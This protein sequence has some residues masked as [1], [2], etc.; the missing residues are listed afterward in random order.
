MKRAEYAPLRADQLRWRCDAA[1]IEALRAA[2]AGETSVTAPAAEEGA[3]QESAPES[4][5]A[6]EAAPDSS[7]RRRVRPPR[8]ARVV[9][10]ERPRAPLSAPLSG[11][12]VSPAPADPLTAEALYFTQGRAL[13]SLQLGIRMEGPGYHIFV[14][15]PSSTGKTSTVKAM[16]RDIKRPQ[17]ARHDFVYVNNFEDAD[18]PHLLTLPAGEGR[19]LKRAVAR[20][21]ELLPEVVHGALSSERVE[22]ARRQLEERLAVRRELDL[23]ALQGEC[24]GAGFTLVKGGEDLA[25]I[26]VAIVVG[27]R[28]KPL[29]IDEWTLEVERGKLK[30]PDV[31]GVLAAH[32]ALELKLHQVWER[33]QAAEWEAKRR[34][35][36]VEVAEMSVALRHSAQ[37]LTPFY[38]KGEPASALFAWVEGLAKWI[39]DHLEE[40]KEYKSSKEEPLD[41]RDVRVLQVNLIHEAAAEPPVIFEQSPTL[42]NLLGTIERSGDDTHPHLDYG[43]IRGGSLLKANGGVLVVNANDMATDAPLWR[44][45]LRALRAR[46]LEIQSPDQLFASGGCPLKPTP[47]PLDVKVLAIGD[48]E[49]YRA[50]FVSNDDFG[51]VFKIKVE[52]DDG[53]PNAPESVGLYVAHADRVAREEGLPPFSAAAVGLW[54]EFGTRL[55]G[56]QDRLSTQL[57]TLTDVLREASFY[58]QEEGGARA[59]EVSAAH[60][61]R[62]LQQRFE[63]HQL[64]EDQLFKMFDDEVIELSPS[65]WEVG[66]AN[67]LTVLD[68]GDHACGHP[69]RISASVSPGEAGVVSVEREVELS[70]RL[71][72]KGALT[73]SAYLRAR[74]LPD[75]VC[76]L[77]ATL[78]FD[79]LH[80]EVEGDSASLAEAV[81]LISALSGAYVDQGVAMTGALDSR[82]R[83]QAIGGVNEKVEGF[84]R[85]CKLKGLTGAQ[86]VV[87]PR[88]NVRDLALRQE[89]IEAVAGG[90]FWLWPVSTVDEALEV[91]CDRAAGES[92]RAP[93]ARL[94]GPPPLDGEE[95]VGAW[96]PAAPLAAPSFPAGSVNFACR[97]RLLALSAVASSFNGAR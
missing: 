15:G 28:R 33:A 29:H 80:D 89:V 96:A 26:E 62:A 55:S 24:A 9:E 52:F 69:C 65:G 47:I 61:R 11:A 53:L 2:R 93:H 78:I 32:E 36:E 31:D 37:S 60:M 92:E 42:I 90:R 83:V 45:L 64:V 95:R 19:A 43:D 84:F 25:T 7:P 48:D 91:L 17:R 44:A 94:E 18:R 87:I 46:A 21:V 35:S 34:L 10:R 12:L 86:G 4:A 49:L 81:A 57:G 13:E 22:R 75:A 76:A 20:F 14:A 72:D 51:R 6:P 97:R 23:E 79:Q 39:E 67:G 5:P 16:L 27:R 50:L 59:A 82:G 66:A 38:A 73:L 77:H 58:A 85:L 56:R 41:L 71:H 3:E 8:G 54:V 63:R 1:L 40:L 70:G 74:Y 68:F 88:A 30:A